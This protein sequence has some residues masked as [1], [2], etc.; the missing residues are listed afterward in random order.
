MKKVILGLTLIVAMTSFKSTD[1]YPCHPLG[2]LYACS[3]PVHSL[4]DLGI[5]RHTY[6]DN[7]GNLCYM[8]AAGDLYPCTHPVHLAGD[9]YPCTHICF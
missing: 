9:L 7:W 4:G 6:Y 5:C 1:S 3:H 2:D 8:H